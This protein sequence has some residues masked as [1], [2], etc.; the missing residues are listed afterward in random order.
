MASTQKNNVTNLNALLRVGAEFHLAVGA[1]T[2]AAAKASGF[3]PFGNIVD[4][5]PNI[6]TQKVEHVSSNRGAP[7]KDREDI[8]RSQIQF[9]V[10][11]DEFTEIVQK[12]MLGGTA[13][14]DFTQSAQNASNGDVLGFTAAPAVIGNWYD[15]SVSNGS[16]IRNITTLTFAGKTEGT[17][18]VV[19]LLT[20]RV[21][22][23]TAQTADLTPVVTAPAITGTSDSSFVG[24][25]PGQQVKLTGIGRLFLF[26]QNTANKVFA[27]YSDFSCEVTLDTA[28]AFNANSFSDLTF[29]VLVTETVGNWATRL[30]AKL[31]SIG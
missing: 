27:D 4:V 10:K 14:T 17:D 3:T 24:I 8:T 11:T 9:K 15:I 16:R 2:L 31:P 25:K 23:L 26:D 12:I 21:S 19:D 30:N 1:T 20:G 13:G 29:S 7:R 18:F 5:T 28:S 6:D 22:F